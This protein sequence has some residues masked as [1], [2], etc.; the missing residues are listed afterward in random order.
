MLNWLF[1]FANG[2]LVFV[3]LPLV[4]LFAVLWAVPATRADLIDK[5]GIIRGMLDELVREFGPVLMTSTGRNAALLGVTGAF[6]AFMPAALAEN[7]AK[8][9]IVGALVWYFLRT[10]EGRKRAAGPILTPLDKNAFPENAAPPVGNRPAQVDEHQGFISPDAPPRQTVAYFEDWLA[11]VDRVA[12]YGENA[13][14]YP[15]PGGETGFPIGDDPT[16]IRF[17]RLRNDGVDQMVAHRIA[18]Q[19]EQATRD[20]LARRGVERRRKAAAD[21]VAK[22]KRRPSPPAKRSA[23]KKTAKRAPAKKVVKKAA[24]R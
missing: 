20:F 1:T 2:A 10:I 23:A 15:I 18:H 7:G 3:V 19:G 24:K 6:G 11:R 22:M 12:G 14:A 16:F 4:L 21:A 5:A 13:A 17:N 9:I 8:A